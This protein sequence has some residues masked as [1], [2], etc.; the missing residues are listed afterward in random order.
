ML[1]ADLHDAIQEDMEGLRRCRRPYFLGGGEMQ[2][3]DR[4]VVGDFKQKAGRRVFIVR[5]EE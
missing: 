2:G 1:T 5:S 3:L 4:L